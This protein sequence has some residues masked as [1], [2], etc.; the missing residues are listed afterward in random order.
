TRRAKEDCYDI[1]FAYENKLVVKLCVYFVIGYIKSFLN[2]EHFD[3]EQGMMLINEAKN[4]EV[5]IFSNTI[6]IP[7]IALTGTKGKT[8]TA[9]IISDILQASGYRVGKA[10][11]HGIFINNECIAE[12]NATGYTSTKKILNDPTI[13]IAV[14]ETS[15]S[16]ILR[17][18]LAYQKAD[19]A[20]FTNMAADN[21]G[22]DDIETMDDLLHIKSL[23]VEAVKNDGVSVLNGDDPYA[24][25]FMERAKGRIILYSLNRN[26]PI[27]NNHMNRGGEI[28]WCENGSIYAI[29]EGIK[30]II[31]DV[32]DIP[33]TLNDS[34]ICNSYNAM[35]AISACYALGISLDTI[36]DY[37]FQNE[38]T[39]S[40]SR[41]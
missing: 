37:F 10:T 29:K 7:V 41:V 16:S 30:R 22:K 33:A 11:T 39:I 19:V 24:S 14:L 3:F 36:A 18:G 12:G 17:E 40:T 13:E 2:K 21:L 20:V 1:V 27:I 5:P 31:I 15:R 8:I 32:A 28:I 25:D 26:T 4:R 6:S 35:A 34:P 38:G 9:G 23:V